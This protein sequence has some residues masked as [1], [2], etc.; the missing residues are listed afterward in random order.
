MTMSSLTWITQSPTSLWALIREMV[1]KIKNGS[2]AFWSS[3]QC[4]KLMKAF[5]LR[6]GRRATWVSSKFLKTIK[7][8]SCCRV[9]FMIKM[10]YNRQSLS[11][12]SW[13][14]INS[15]KDCSRTNLCWQEWWQFKRK[16]NRCKCR[17]CHQ[18]RHWKSNLICQFPTI[19][20]NLELQSMIL[21]R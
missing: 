2:Q 9:E 17:M 11:P 8:F 18:D 16:L 6:T 10:L 21:E 3:F 13:T 12:R 14:W 7:A 1:F 19:S 20:Y 4:Q 15:R 5:R